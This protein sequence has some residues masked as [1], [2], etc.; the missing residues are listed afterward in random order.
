M[1]RRERWFPE[2]GHDDVLMI[3][4]PGSGADKKVQGSVVNSR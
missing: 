1:S 3:E 2:H 4:T